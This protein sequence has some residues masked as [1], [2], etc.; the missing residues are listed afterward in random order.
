MVIRTF[1]FRFFW[2]FFF[3]CM[4]KF[5]SCIMQRVRHTLSLSHFLGGRQ[6]LILKKLVSRKYTSPKSRGLFF[7]SNGVSN[8]TRHDTTR[9]CSLENWMRHFKRIIYIALYNPYNYSPTFFFLH[10]LIFSFFL[11]V[12][13]KKRVYSTH[14]ISHSYIHVLN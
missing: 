2:L 6:Q 5:R 11:V 1:S 14:L 3:F 7:F 9:H 10:N 12:K 8:A 13:K 4:M